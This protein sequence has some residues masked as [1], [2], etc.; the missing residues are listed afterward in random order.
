MAAMKMKQKVISRS[1]GETMALAEGLG[2][3]AVGGTVFALVGELGSG[4]TI[5]AK[6]L[7]RG[8][9]VTDEI[10]SPTFTL[11]EIYAGRFPLYHFDLYRIE[12]GDEL[13]RLYFEEYWYDESGVSVIEWA[14]RALERLPDGY[15]K[16]EI[17]YIDEESRSISIEHTGL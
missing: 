2:R 14:D 16:I 10:T 7:A 8:M 12:R 4:K 15:I 9:G 13:D 1:V 6:G 5:F 11:L 17:S 3:K